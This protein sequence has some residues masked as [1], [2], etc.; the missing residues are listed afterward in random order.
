MSE[1]IKSEHANVLNA[2]SEMQGAVCYAVRRADLRAAEDTIVQLER[3]N[4]TL[5]E[6][7][8][9]LKELLK[10]AHEQ[11]CSTLCPSVKKTG[12]DW[13]HVTLCLDMTAALQ[14]AKPTRDG[15]EG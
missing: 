6:E 2:L 10:L 7:H 5:R 15:G 14:P 12:T 9:R 1:G 4:A 11:F 13:T 8:R 3:D